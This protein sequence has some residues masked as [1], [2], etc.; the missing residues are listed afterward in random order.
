M[1][2]CFAGREITWEWVHGHNG[3]PLNEEVDRLAND[4]ARKAIFA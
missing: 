3:G 1:E 4:A 2:A